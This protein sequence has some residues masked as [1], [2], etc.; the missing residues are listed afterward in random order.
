[1]FSLQLHLFKSGRNPSQ[2]AVNFP[3]KSNWIC[4]HQENEAAKPVK[5][6][7]CQTVCPLPM[8]TILQHPGLSVEI[9][10]LLFHNYNCSFILSSV[11]KNGNS[12]DTSWFY[13]EQRDFC[14]LE[15][16]QQ[17]FKACYLDEC[18]LPII[19]RY[20]SVLYGFDFLL[21]TEGILATSL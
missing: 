9:F 21:T 12:N 7:S 2:Y 6:T 13:L 14:L 8:T 11:D 3:P 4:K 10:P 18:T 1:M 15:V 17:E 20:L 16:K 5:Q 19:G